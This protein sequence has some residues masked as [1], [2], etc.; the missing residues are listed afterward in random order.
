MSTSKLLKDDEIAILINVSEEYTI[1][2]NTYSDNY[3][4]EGNYT[5]KYKFQNG[6]ILDVSITTFTL[7]TINVEKEEK[8]ETFITKAKRFFNKIINFFKNLFNCIILKDYRF[9]L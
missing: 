5:I 7:S 4:V 6:D 2:E 8:K 3:S 1:I 9:F